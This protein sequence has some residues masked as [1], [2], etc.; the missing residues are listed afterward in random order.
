MST[1]RAAAAAL[2]LAGAVAGCGEQDAPP[3]PPSGAG[4]TITP[5]VTPS[6]PGPAPDAVTGVAADEV[7]GLAQ[8]VPP[9]DLVVTSA[10]RRPDAADLPTYLLVGTTTVEGAAD[11][12]A[13]LG[14]LVP[15][16]DGLSDADRAG[17]GLAEDPAGDLGTCRAADPVVPSV[18]RDVLVAEADGGATVWLSTYETP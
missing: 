12:C 5:Q 14:D 16:P 4:R 7:W 6:G 11:L 17:W 1:S 15:V 2:V 13:Q 18:Q 8:L 3:E 9:A 10:A